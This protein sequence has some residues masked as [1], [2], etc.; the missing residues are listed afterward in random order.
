MNIE[1]SCHFGDMKTELSVDPGLKWV[2]VDDI[3]TEGFCENHAKIEEFTGSQ[4][5]G[6]VGGWGDC[7]LWTAFAHR[8]RGLTEEDFAKIR[9]G[10][11]PKRTNGTIMVNADM[12]KVESV[13]LSEKANDESGAALEIAIREYWERYEIGVGK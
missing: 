10:I 6:C 11:C 1:I 9:K 2:G 12:R 13:D 8:S 5:P 4:C 7:E 3:Y